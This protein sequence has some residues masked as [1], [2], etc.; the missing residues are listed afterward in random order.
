MAAMISSKRLNEESQKD[1]D[2]LAINEVKSPLKL[3]LLSQSKKT[4]LLIHNG[5]VAITDERADKI[6]KPFPELWISMNIKTCNEAITKLGLITNYSK[7]IEI[8]EVSEYDSVFIE[9]TNK[10]TYDLILFILN[11]F[12]TF[13]MEDTILINKTLIDPTKTLMQYKIIYNG[14]KEA[15]FKDKQTIYLYHGSPYTNWYS[16]MRI[17]IKNASTNPNL[18]LHG[19][20]H[21]AGIYLSN[22][23]SLSIIYSKPGVNNWRVLAVYEVINNPEWKKTSDIY[24][25]PDET[26]LILK[27]IIVFN[28]EIEPDTLNNLNTLLNS[29]QLQIMAEK[30]AQE[31]KKTT[32]S[33]GLR[34]I[35]IE[36]NQLMKKINN[37]SIELG[38]TVELPEG[39]GN[40]KLWNIKIFNVD[41]P[42]LQEQ[43]KLLNIPCIILEIRFPEQYPIEPPFIRIL[44]PRFKLLTGHITSGGSICMEALSKQGWIPA[45][46]IE[47][48]IIQIKLAL[49]DGGAIIDESNIGVKYTLENAQIA[50]QRALETH[51]HEWST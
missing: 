31:M 38:F 24:V 16:I 44:S 27:Y 2:E 9:K 23:A 39:D 33:S 5:L 17:G 1:F 47:P 4:K 34:R 13:N 30:K 25:I 29:D 3:L 49:G 48:L 7:I 50:F 26:A 32:I 40:I 15:N 36:Y 21:G 14:D 37:P 8:L 42:K 41:N 46:N 43:M 11:S 22:N 10:N 12:P 35:T 6:F 28:Y 51:K 19:A 20:V 45:T 18:F